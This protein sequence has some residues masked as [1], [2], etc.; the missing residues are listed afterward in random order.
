MSPLFYYWGQGW[1]I[2]KPI[3]YIWSDLWADAVQ[4]MADLVQTLPSRRINWSPRL[5]TQSESMRH[6]CSDDGWFRAG[7]IRS[8]VDPDW[9]TD[10]LTCIYFEW[11]GGGGIGE[12]AETTMQFSESLRADSIGSAADSVEAY[13][14][15][16][17]L[18]VKPKLQLKFW[19][20]LQT[21]FSAARFCLQLKLSTRPADMTPS[22]P[23]IRYYLPMTPSPPLTVS[24][25]STQHCV[26]CRWHPPLHSV[27]PAQHPVPCHLPMTTLSEI[28]GM[29]IY[30]LV[31]VCVCGGGGGGILFRGCPS[32]GV[33][34][35]CISSHARWELP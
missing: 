34:V 27:R 33:Y 13:G 31:C 3:K 17:L 21:C 2:V 9:T 6:R 8:P 30:L 32:G 5:I 24:P 29:I 35:H 4:W 14:P 20:Q 12:E 15:E 23:S 28:E 10:W 22:A 26:T 18:K 11:G 16:V 7:P 25:F 1:L 19:L